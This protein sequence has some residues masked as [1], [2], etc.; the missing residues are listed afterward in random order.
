MKLNQTHTH[1]ERSISEIKTQLHGAKIEY[2]NFYD[3]A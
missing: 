1:L 3:N 2:N